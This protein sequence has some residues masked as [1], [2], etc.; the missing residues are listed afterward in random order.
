MTAKRSP[1]DFAGVQTF[2]Y[3]QSSLIGL[4]ARSRKIMSEKTGACIQRGP[5][6]VAFTMPF[7][8]LTGSRETRGRQARRY[9]CPVPSRH[10]SSLDLSQ[11][12][13]SRTASQAIQPTPCA[14]CP[15]L[16]SFL[17]PGLVAYD[18]KPEGFRLS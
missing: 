13:R 9:S 5:N 8:G 3:K 15:Q 16:G 11:T 17:P 1:A 10:Q 4:A 18:N 2:K 12:R 6:S 14:R 7:E